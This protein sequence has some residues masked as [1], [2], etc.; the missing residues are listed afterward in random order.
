MKI[1][2]DFRKYDGVIGG[3]EQGVIQI[4]RYVTAHGHRVVLLCKK[5]RLVEV[6][7]IFKGN[8]SLKI[9]PLNVNTHIIN[10]KN[11]Q[12]DSSTI[13]EAYLHGFYFGC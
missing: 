7:S 4:T 10:R 11:A 8:L 2:M 3:V 13:Q 9:V 12:L 5:S 1:V 6:E